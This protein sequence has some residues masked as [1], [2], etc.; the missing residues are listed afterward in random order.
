[1]KGKKVFKIDKSPTK[2]FIES[3][4]DDFEEFNINKMLQ[5]NSKNVLMYTRYVHKN[6]E[7]PP[8]LMNIMM[9]DRQLQKLEE[10]YKTIRRIRDD[11]KVFSEMIQYLRRNFVLI[12]KES[13]DEIKRINPESAARSRTKPTQMS[14]FSTKPNEENT[15][16]KF[17]HQVKNLEDMRKSAQEGPTASTMERKMSK[18]KN[19]EFIQKIDLMSGRKDQT[20]NAKSQITKEISTDSLPALKV[21]KVPLLKWQPKDSG[22]KDGI[23][24]DEPVYG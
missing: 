10:N 4:R 17:N 9:M 2:K 23:G 6:F 22:R 1:M 12:S 13:N 20:Q 19:D 16:S 15:I 11:E 18:V 8:V 5:W 14:Q 24:G 7:D 3:F 21:Q